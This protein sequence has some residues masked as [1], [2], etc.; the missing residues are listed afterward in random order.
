MGLILSCHGESGSEL[1]VLLSGAWDWRA[2]GKSPSK[3]LCSSSLMLT[4]SWLLSASV[5]AGL[6]CRGTGLQARLVTV[7]SGRLRSASSAE[8]GEIRT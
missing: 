8:P 5:W 2:D 7:V 1:S 6:P 4:C 3:R